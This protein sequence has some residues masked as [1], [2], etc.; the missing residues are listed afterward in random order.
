MLTSFFCCTSIHFNVPSGR[1]LDY[2]TEAFALPGLA[3]PAAGAGATPGS[4]P[5]RL[6]QPAGAFSNPN[7][8][9]EP[10]TLEVPSRRIQ[11]GAGKCCSISI[12]IVS[13]Q[14][15][16]GRYELSTILG[17]YYVAILIFK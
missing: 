12:P 11:R 2:V 16:E 14:K 1:S 4:K 9:L 5:V 6:R 8:A 13:I 10:A 15:T 3:V 17:L 7:A